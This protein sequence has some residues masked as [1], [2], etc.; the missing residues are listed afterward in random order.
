M[1][2]AQII[3]IRNM[4]FMSKLNISFMAST[5]FGIVRKFV[6]RNNP[7]YKQMQFALN[8][9]KM[10]KIAQQMHDSSRVYTAHI[11][12]IKMATIYE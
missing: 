6:R 8:K 10:K 9:T 5:C 2:A 1:F 12:I 3:T 11:M 7:V 4:T